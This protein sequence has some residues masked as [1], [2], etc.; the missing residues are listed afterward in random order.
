MKFF[1]KNTENE[2]NLRVKCKNCKKF[3]KVVF[4]KGID[5]NKNIKEHPCENCDV[6]ALKILRNQSNEDGENNFGEFNDIFGDFFDREGFEDESE[7]KG[8]KLD[9]DGFICLDTKDKFDYTLDLNG[10][11]H[12]FNHKSMKEAMVDY[13]KKKEKKKS[14]KKKSSRNENWNWNSYR[15]SS[16]REYWKR[17]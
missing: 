5:A 17:G 15:G 6:K 16:N 2:Y 13:I 7:N 12:K 8:F 14:E 4:Q 9:D 3:Q 1:K 10:K 11:K